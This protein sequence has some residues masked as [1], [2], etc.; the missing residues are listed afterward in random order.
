M[1]MFGEHSSSSANRSRAVSEWS[2]DL[3]KVLAHAGQGSAY[4]TIGVIR[5]SKLDYGAPD[6]NW[7]LVCSTVLAV[8]IR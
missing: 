5:A 1:R 4:D 3:T 8:C 6:F 2:A 7:N